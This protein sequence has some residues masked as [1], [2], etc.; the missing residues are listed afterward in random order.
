MMKLRILVFGLGVAA[1]GCGFGD[2]AARRL[3]DGH[4][5]CGDG[6]RDPGEGCDDG[7]RLESDGCSAECAVEVADP[8]CG[9]GT[10]EVGEACD[11]GN[12][13]SNDGCS[14]TCVVE[15]VCGNGTREAGEACDDGNHTSGDGC[16]PTC[17]V[18]TETACGLVPQTGCP[19]NEACDFADAPDG[20]TACRPITAAG[21]SDHRCS[22]ATAC[23]AG[24]TCVSAAGDDTVSWC[25]KLCNVDA[26]CGTD[27]KCA[28]GLADY[29]GD[30]LN[31]MV[32]SNACDVLTQTGCPTGTACFPRDRTGGDVTTCAGHGT[33]PHHQICTSTEDCLPGAA[34][35]GSNGTGTCRPYCDLDNPHCG[36]GET[37]V[38][39]VNTL[40]VNGIS[41]GSCRR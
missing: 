30:P 23:A 37:C 2:N 25:N 8:E 21:T 36:V 41:Y 32:C 27:A 14:A 10:R 6:S 18:E 26:D 3:G 19:A 35:V 15:S 4:A 17:Q 13:T 1:S 40:L 12:A 31:V 22:T 33:T 28:I 9:N 20:E 16:S 24:Y 11:D 5:T 38:G 7:N 39:F 29:N 34:C